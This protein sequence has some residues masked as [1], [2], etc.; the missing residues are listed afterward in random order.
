M[1]SKSAAF[2]LQSGTTAELQDKS[3]LPGFHKDRSPYEIIGAPTHVQGAEALKEISPHQFE[4]WA[5]VARPSWPWAF[6]GGTPMHRGRLPVL[7]ARC[8]EAGVLKT[9]CALSIADLPNR[10]MS[11]PPAELRIHGKHTLPRIPAA[12]VVL[13][14]SEESRWAVPFSHFAG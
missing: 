10:A 14:A 13:S 9:Q 8:G 11:T 7:P 3:S 12:P 6:T 2:D 4:W 1:V 5:V